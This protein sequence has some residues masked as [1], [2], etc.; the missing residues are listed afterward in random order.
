MEISLQHLTYRYPGRE[1]TSLGPIDL[2]FAP[3]TVTVLTGATG[4]GKST[5]LKTLNGLIPR[6]AAGELNGD[7]RLDGTAIASLSHAEVCR[8]VGLVLQSADD[9]LVSTLVGD[10]ARFGL[11]N[12]GLDRESVEAMS[13]AA[14][15]RV[16][17]AEQRDAAIATLSG[18]Q[19]QRLAIASILAM[20]PAVVAVD[21]PLSQLDPD[22]VVDALALLDELAHHQG[23]TVVL[24]EHRLEEALRIADRLLVLAHGRVVADGPPSAILADSS[25]LRASGIEVPPLCQLAELHGLSARPLIDADALAALATVTSAPR[26]QAAAPTRAAC[27]PALVVRDLAFQHAPGTRSPSTCARSSSSA[28]RPWR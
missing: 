1:Q 24:A 23:L 12:L 26:P 10:E 21:E 28:A 7:V 27:A 5:L 14:L 19:R 17:L 11:E 3:G 15:E 8:R 16:G 18:G 4:S 22:G 20:R 2:R 9:Q 6:S 13:C 25:A